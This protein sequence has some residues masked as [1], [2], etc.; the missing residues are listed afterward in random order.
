MYYIRLHFV[1]VPVTSQ[2][3]TNH[4]HYSF[5]FVYIIPFIQTIYHFI[6]FPNIFSVPAKCTLVV[7]CEPIL[8]SDHRRQNTVFIV[9]VYA[10]S[11][12]AS[13]PL[14]EISEWKFSKCFL[15]YVRNIFPSLAAS[16][17]YLLSTRRVVWRFILCCVI[18]IVT[19]TSSCNDSFSTAKGEQEKWGKSANLYHIVFRI[20]HSY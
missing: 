12:Y 1:R 14:V 11:L 6:S 8:K 19:A 5:I 7:W 9:F 20:I 17:A 13:R 10:I 3:S 16:R 18:I 15:L 4:I 2:S